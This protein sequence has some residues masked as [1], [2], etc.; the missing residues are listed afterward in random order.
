MNI[1]ATRECFGPHS[2]EQQERTAGRELS[3]E[4]FVDVDFCMDRLNGTCG[5]CGCDFCFESKTARQFRLD[6]IYRDISI[7]YIYTVTSHQ[8]QWRP[9]Y[10]LLLLSPTTQKSQTCQASECSFPECSRWCVPTL[11]LRRP[12]NFIYKF[13]SQNNNHRYCHNI[14][15]TIL[16]LEN[17]TLV[18]STYFY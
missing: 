3:E 7:L 16:Q 6:N 5:R 11:F 17:I 1:F 14:A 12:N 2:L 15:I 4:N 18:S 9:L 8:T 10:F 13:P